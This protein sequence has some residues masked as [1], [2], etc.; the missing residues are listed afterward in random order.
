MEKLNRYKQVVEKT[1][2]QRALAGKPSLPMSE[3]EQM[4][5]YL[6]GAGMKEMDTYDYIDELEEELMAKENN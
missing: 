2:R 4:S 6:Q 5:V 1:I 3:V